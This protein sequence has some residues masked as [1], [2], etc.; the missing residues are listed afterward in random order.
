M[1]KDPICGMYVE[2]KPDA[3]KANQRGTTYYFCSD[4]CLQTFVA[5]A[6]ELKSIRRVTVLSF[7]LGIPVLLLTWFVMLP[8]WVPQSLLLFALAT[9][10]Q[11][12]AGWVFY[13][14]TWHAI[15]ARVANMDTLVATGT[16]AAWAYS[17]IV[18][19]A[20]GVLPEGIYFDASSL[21]IGFILLGKLLEHAMRG[22]ASDAVRK[23][24]DISPKK[25]TVVRG[26]KESEVPVEEVVVG[27]SVLI[28]PGEKVP[29]DGAIVEGSSS[30]DE[31]M[32]TGESIPVEKNP[33]DEVYGATINQTGLLTV[34]ATKV[35]SDTALAQ[36]VK[37]VE[38][39]HAAQAPVQRLADRIA[40]Y[41]VPLVILVAVASLAGWYLV[42]GKG[43]LYGFTAFIAVLIIACPCA[44][45]LATPAALVVGTGKGASNGI[46]LKGGESLERASNVDEVV[47][48]K[49]GTITVGEPSVT[50]VVP[51]AGL[52]DAQLLGLAAAIEGG[53]EHPLGMAIARAASERGIKLERATDFRAEPGMGVTGK[54]G[55]RGV[56]VGNASLFASKGIELERATDVVSKFEEEGKTT[57][58]VGVD[59]RI[60]GVVVVADRVKPHAKEA[61]TSLKKMGIRVVMLTGDKETTARAVAGQVG[62]DEVVAEVLPGQKSDAIK[63]LRQGGHVVAMVGDGINDAPAL[64]QANVGIAIGSGTDIAIETAGI[65]LMKGDLRDVVGALRLSRATMSKIRQ[66]LFWAFSYNTILIPVAASGFLNP[67]LA[68][69]AMALSSVSVVANS[70]LLDRV[71]LAS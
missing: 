34:R 62:I 51:L 45:G 67:I 47:F 46:L 43:L 31:K 44:L 57:I 32:L 18:V 30:V 59:G 58:I 11:F 20:P 52:S 13:R 22:R 37:L 23:L 54:V 35:G 48:D 28:R 60:S 14:G 65:V 49:T 26:G 7:A 2:E 1:A 55:G 66:N 15:R 8:R 41:F 29:T 64:A 27:D 63:K 39:A 33:G 5:P 61:V 19:F 42:A 17:T 10:V 12:V 16:T 56:M 38:E 68:G 70:L 24:L 3:L 6:R 69:V 4:T 50:D 36:I 25:A 53:S 71:K 21:I 9:P 40:A